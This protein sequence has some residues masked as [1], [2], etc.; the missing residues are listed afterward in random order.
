[1]L[2]LFKDRKLN[3]WNTYNS[4]KLLKYEILLEK[5]LMQSVNIG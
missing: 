3:K 5:K 1:M 4:V 2:Q